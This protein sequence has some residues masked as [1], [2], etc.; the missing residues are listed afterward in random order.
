MD[1]A[2]AMGLGGPNAFLAPG[3]D[4][5]VPGGV[6]GGQIGAPDAG[7]G[8][9]GSLLGKFEQ[10]PGLLLSGGIL[11]ME[12]LKGNQPYPAEQQLSTLATNVG[13]TGRA[14]DSYL[15]SGTLPPGAQ[16]AVTQAAES[17]KATTRS[18]YAQLG[19][20]GSTMEA[21]ALQRIDQSAAAQTFQIADQLLAQG[22]N[23]SQISGQLYNDILQSQMATDK[24]LMASLSAFAGG[25]AGLRGTSAG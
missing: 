1:G 21:E 13:S 5:A 23:Y 20:S 8:F 7:G 19:L 10:N 25:L 11:G 14:L 15:F 17:A 3:T 18:R 9:I 2:S 16:Q 22:A 12:L 24:E 6:A 4:T